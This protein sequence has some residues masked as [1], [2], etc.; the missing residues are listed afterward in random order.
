LVLTLLLLGIIV[1]GFRGKLGFYIHPRYHL[2]TMV[3]CGLAIILLLAAA[4]TYRFKGRTN[5]NF[6][7]WPSLIVVFGRWL[8]GRG[9]WLVVLAAVTT[10]IITPSP[11]LSS[12]ANHKTTAAPVAEYVLKSNW[13]RHPS[14]IYE[15]SS[16]LSVEEGARQLIDQH[17]KLTG[18]V[19]TPSLGDSA[20]SFW[21]SRFVIA[22][23]AVDATP[24]SL[25]VFRPGWDKELDVDSWVE[26][27]GQIKAI[28]T[29]GQVNFYLVADS[30]QA[31]DQPIEPYDYI[32][33]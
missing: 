30:I 13:F 16:V 33:F 5:I 19:R 29:G 10:L 21:L 17:F 26:V 20:N 1:Q 24:V 2:L 9:S 18:F 14:T 3:S 22:C 31:V 27:E 23:C 28:N 6:D 11:M 8:L 7:S 4:V 32:S 25:P 15:I 12:V